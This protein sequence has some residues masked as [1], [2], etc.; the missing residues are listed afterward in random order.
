MNQPTN[1]RKQI[2]TE[3]PGEYLS[4][5]MGNEPFGKYWIAIEEGEGAAYDE[6]VIVVS[7]PVAKSLIV[8]LQEAVERAE[9]GGV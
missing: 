9:G 6:S 3:L 8:V 7:L 4:V 2:P 5:E 1:F